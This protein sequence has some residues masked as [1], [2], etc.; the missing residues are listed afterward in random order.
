MNGPTTAQ[1]QARRLGEKGLYQQL[2]QAFEHDYGF[3]KGRRIIPT[4][5]HDILDKVRDYYG[6]DR[7]QEPS[8]IVYTAAQ[9]SAR[10]T[11]GKTMAQTAQ[12]AIRLT[13]VAPEDCVA[14]GQGAPPLLRQRLLRW[15]HEAVAQGALLTTADLAFLCGRPVASVAQ[16]IR[17]YERDTGKLLPLRGTVHDA[18]SKLTHKARIVALYLAGQLP[19]EIA[20]ATDHSIEAVEHYLR[21]FALVRELA[22][23]YDA[24]G[25]SHLIG[26]GVRVVHE[27][28]ALLEGPPARP[29]PTDSD[30]SAASRQTD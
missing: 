25:I 22:T 12:Q 21:D 14:Y 15:L 2:C 4:I 23:R 10:L 5:V 28:L 7:A 6:P 29:G 27:Y 17:E 20:R 9:A 30:K 1:K 18:S 16:L 26:R 3:D 24:E 13:M 19:P 8:Q 11:R